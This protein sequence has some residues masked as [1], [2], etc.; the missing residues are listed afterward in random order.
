MDSPYACPIDVKNLTDCLFYHTT[1]LP[2]LPTVSGAWDLRPG[3]DRYLG[4]VSF[5]GKRVLDVGAATGFLS[6]YMERQG[7]EVVSFDLSDTHSWDLVPYAGTDLIGQLR[8]TRAS[9][10]RLN[11]GYWYC[12]RALGSRNR[13]VYGTAYQIPPSIGPVDIGVFGS[14]LEHLRDPFL[15]LQTGLQLVKHTV[16][17]A[18]TIPRRR[19]WQRWLPWL[20]RPELGFLP[21]AQHPVHG[22]TWWTLTPKVVKRF[23]GV[24]GFEDLKVIYHS[25]QFE[26]STRLL[27]TIVGQRT[28]PAPVLEP[29][30]QP[31]RSVA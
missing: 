5:Q 29:L 12:H 10:R 7:A 20:V 1:D 3:I 31:A 4:G 9:I 30:H 28:R 16:I 18:E 2:G 24:L 6:F 14:I 15:A 11:N 13:V 8:D 21:D 22:A 17:V 23:L 27:Y 26:G 25:Q 19:F